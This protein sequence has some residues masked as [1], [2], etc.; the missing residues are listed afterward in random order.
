MLKGMF[1]GVFCV[2][3]TACGVNQ[4]Q[5]PLEVS[6]VVEYKPLTSCDI[7]SGHQGEIHSG[8]GELVGLWTLGISR[9]TERESSAWS[10]H[11]SFFDTRCR[12]G[13]VTSDL[14]KV[15]GI[16]IFSMSIGSRD[17]DWNIL[18][19]QWSTGKFDLQG[20]GLN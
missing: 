6:G 8:T 19:S 10:G 2:S 1:I 3:L 20:L 13:Y 4:S 17:L 11:K 18:E 16:L 9:A 14:G 5:L 12:V 15:K 7:D